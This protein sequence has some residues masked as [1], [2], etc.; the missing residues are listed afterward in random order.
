MVGLVSVCSIYACFRSGVDV[1]GYLAQWEGSSPISLATVGAKGG[2]W[3]AAAVT[4]APV[5][6]LVLLTS[7]AVGR[8]V[9]RRRAAA[10]VTTAPLK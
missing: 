2:Q 8:A 10:A 3:A 9:G 1:Q 6:P 5:F 4:S 7:G